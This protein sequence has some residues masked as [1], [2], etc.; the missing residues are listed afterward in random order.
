[1]DQTLQTLVEQNSGS[2]TLITSVAVILLV[3]GTVVFAT[4]AHRTGRSDPAQA[5]TASSLYGRSISRTLG[6]YL[7]LT[8]PVV[9]V[10]LV[11]T[12]GGAMVVAQQGLPPFPLLALT[13]LGGAMTAGG[14]NAIN[15]YIDRDIDACMERTARRPLPSG[16]VAPRNALCFGLAL[17]AGGVLVLALGANLLSAGLAFVGIAYYVGIYT[18]LLKR[19]TPHNVVIGGAAGGIP[20]LVGWAA[21]TNGLSPLAG[22]LFLI[23]FAWTPPHTWALMLMLTKDYQRVGVPMMPVAHGEPATRRQIVGYSLLLVV[24]TLLPLFS[25]DAGPAYLI[26]ALLLGGWFLYLAVGLWRSQSK[27]AARRLYVYSNAYL[28]LLFLAMALDRSILY[29]H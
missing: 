17:C 8:K 21:V 13:L 4:L 6:Q 12:T 29:L 1:M 5:Q 20:P 28:A 10:L 3:V 11:A 23:I 25:R 27:P 22:L 9:V 16:A 26:A 14:S 15:S 19:R 24:V 7:K 2:L 18:L